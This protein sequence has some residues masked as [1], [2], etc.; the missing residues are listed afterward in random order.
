LKASSSRAAAQK[1]L[2]DQERKSQS[3]IETEHEEKENQN[4]TVNE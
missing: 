3:W 4:I 1:A 2:E